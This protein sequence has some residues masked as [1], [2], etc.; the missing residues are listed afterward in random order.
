MGTTQSFEIRPTMVG[1]ILF[2][3][4]GFAFLKHLIARDYG[5]LNY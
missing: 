1:T 3:L 2:K 4:I 5:D